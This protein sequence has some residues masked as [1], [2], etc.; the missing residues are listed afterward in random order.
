MVPITTNLVM[1]HPVEA[2][3]AAAH[4]PTTTAPAAAVAPATTFD[5]APIRRLMSPRGVIA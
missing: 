2:A 1:P 3:V 5:R 4:E